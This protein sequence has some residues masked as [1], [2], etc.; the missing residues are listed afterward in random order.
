MGDDKKYYKI[1]FIGA[2]LIALLLGGGIGSKFFPEQKVIYKKTTSVDTLTEVDTMFKE[3]IVPRIKIRT[4]GVL[5]YKTDTVYLTK[6]FIATVDTIMKEDTL[7]VSYEFPQNIFEI[8]LR[9]KPLEEKTIIKY[10]TITEEVEKPEAW[11]VHPAWAVGGLL[12]G[13]GLGSIK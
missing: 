13:Y 3:V 11:W 9:R 5:V 1:L 2:L 10:V 7:A 6:P 8:D 12:V 4:E